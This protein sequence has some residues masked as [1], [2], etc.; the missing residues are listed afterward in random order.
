MES[1]STLF[2]HSIHQMVVPFPI[3]A[4]GLSVA[5]DAYYTLSGKREHAR[6]ARRALDFGLVTAA[7][8]APFGIGDYL[9][10]DPDSRAK[11]VGRQHALTNVV[12]LGMFATSRLMRRGGTAPLSARVLSGA[13]FALSGL[14]AWFGGEL[15][16]RHGIG[17]SNRVG[18]N[19]PGS[20]QEGAPTTNRDSNEETAR[21]KAPAKPHRANLQTESP[22]TW[23]QPQSADIDSPDEH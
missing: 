18:Q 6:F 20:L 13:A 22:G 5:M 11:Q 16:S 8:A 15:L 4:F 7:V 2:G 9:A 23:Q 17:L 12:M 19:V 1:R 21:G 10:I 3:G 14:G